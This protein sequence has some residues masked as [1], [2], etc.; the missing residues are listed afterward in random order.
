MPRLPRA[1]RSAGHY[2]I[3][4]LIQKVYATSRRTFEADYLCKG[5]RSEGLW[6][7]EFYPGNIAKRAEYDPRLELHLAID[8]GATTG[9]VFF[10]VARLHD[11]FSG[12]D[13]HEV[14]VL[15]DYLCENKPAEQVA[16]ELREIAR[17][18]FN[19]R[20]DHFTMDSAGG[21]RTAVGPRVTEL[22]A[23]GG[24][25]NPR[26]WPKYA[27]SVTDQLALM[28]SLVRAAN[29]R[30]ALLI[31]PTCKRTIQAFENYRRARRGG[32]WQD[33]PEDPQ[34]PHEDLIDALRGGVASALPRGRDTTPSGLRTVQGG[35]LV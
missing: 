8:P 31:H 25:R 27:G 22:Y 17:S 23:L 30:R 1:K 24:L 21:A 26:Y 33:Y 10:Q 15:A 14:L 3:D 18:R 32:Q 9:A 12:H 2:S 29:G 5:P 20:I 28:E 11:P 35:F 19:D 4:S 7:P 34:H 16:L 6:F 13:L